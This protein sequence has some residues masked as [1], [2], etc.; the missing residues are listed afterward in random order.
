MKIRYIIAH[1][2]FSTTKIQPMHQ[3]NLKKV[4]VFSTKQWFAV[5][6]EIWKLSMQTRSFGEIY[7]LFISEPQPCQSDPIRNEGKKI[8]KNLFVIK[9]LLNK[10]ICCENNDI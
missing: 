4:K 2:K 5:H 3:R 9:F 7:E 1:V 8:Y 6:D 10:T